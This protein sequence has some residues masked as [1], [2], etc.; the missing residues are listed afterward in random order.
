[1][2]KSSATKT[3]ADSTMALLGQAMD[4][5]SRLATPAAPPPTTPMP[6]APPV[7][8][9][10]SAPPRAAGA[11]PLAVPVRPAIRTS[12]L[13]FTAQDHQRINRII[14]RSLSLGQRIPMSDAVRLALKAYD[15]QSLTDADLA[16]LDATDGRLRCRTSAL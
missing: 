2:S 6:G 16:A 1:M 12:G 9:L 11:R 8:A 7:A 3:L 13:R 5:N 4:R 10:A 14:N 15:P